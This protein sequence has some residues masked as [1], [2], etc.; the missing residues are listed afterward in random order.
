M[1]QNVIDK[2]KEVLQIEA[3]A[4]LALRDRL[5]HKFVRVV[6]MMLDCKG[7][8]VVMGMGKPGLIGRKIAATLASTGTPALSLHP[9]EALHGDLGMIIKDDVVLAIS[10][11]GETEEIVRIIPRIKRIGA[12]LIA[13]TGNLNS[14]L[15]RESNLSLNISVQEEACPLGLAPTASTTATLVMGDAL[16]LALLHK[17]GFRREDYAFYHPGGSLG[18][19][20]L[21]VEEIMRIG[22]KNPVVRENNTV[23]EV[24]F[25][26]TKARAG[27]ACIVDKQGK[28]LGI[29]T[30]GDLRRHIERN[31][32]VTEEVIG[33]VMTKKP[34]TV[35]KDHLALDALAILREKNIDE[36]PVVDSDGKLVGLLDVQDLLKAGIVTGSNE[37]NAS[38]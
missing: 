5:D 9:A 16:A 31:A 8:V 32:G 19:K 38:G 10:N 4:V 7:R 21:R 15:A 33:A 1:Q 37:C 2:A 18:K 14:T 22:N 6:E 13:L 25:A 23:Q 26:I 3:A 35:S 27:A 34:I 11:S 20:L 29:F 12:K 36:L 17:R 24:L 28:L 30:D